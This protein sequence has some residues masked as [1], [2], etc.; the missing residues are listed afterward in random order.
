MKLRLLLVLFVA[1]VCSVAAPELHAQTPTDTSSSAQAQAPQ[2][3]P[4]YSLPPEK[5]Q[6]AIEYSRI[7]VIL[8]FVDSGSS[9]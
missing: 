8:D 6:K 3:K 7:R 9:G 4:A 5:L 1:F 2:S